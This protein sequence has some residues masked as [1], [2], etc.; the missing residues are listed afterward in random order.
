MSFCMTNFYKRISHLKKLCFGIQMDVGMD[1]VKVIVL[2]QLVLENFSM[3]VTG[4]MTQALES[5]DW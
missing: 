4:R 3:E 2:I 5:C 1:F